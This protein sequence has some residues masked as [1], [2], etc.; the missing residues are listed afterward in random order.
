[1]SRSLSVII[2]TLNEEE[3]LAA[4]L[5]ALPAGVEVVVADGGS[6]DATPAI[7]KAHGAR[8]VVTGPG[9]ARQLNHGAAAAGGAILLFVH[10]DT[11]LP[12]GFAGEV[13][14]CLARPGAVAGA[15][16]LRL[17]GGP[18]GLGLVAWGAN[19]RSRLGRLP[20]GDQGLFM[21]RE[22]FRFV[23]GF[24]EVALLED[25]MMVCALRKQ[26]K[27]VLSDRSVQ[28]SGRRWQQQGLIRTTLINQLLLGGFFLGLSPE[29]LAQF[30]G[31]RKEIVDGRLLR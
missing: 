28:S 11:V 21:A 29:F 15:F 9:R 25:V 24:P 27:V 1:M 13:E 3:H 17:V 6:R 22:M 18:R 12:V 23:G 14:A 16:R 7:A 31:V 19:V 5:A 10:A 2:P 4:T 20:Y 26:G 30:Y 8:L